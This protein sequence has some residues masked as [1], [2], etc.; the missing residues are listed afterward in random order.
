MCRVCCAKKQS[1]LFVRGQLQKAAGTL[2]AAA[3]VMHGEV[4]VQLEIHAVTVAHMERERERER[5]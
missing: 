1:S 4:Q 5:E 3:A 2:L